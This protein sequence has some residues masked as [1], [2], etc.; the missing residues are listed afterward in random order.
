MPGTVQT[1][2]ITGDR[3]MKT[4]LLGRTLMAAAVAGLM[5]ASYLAGV[6]QGAGNEAV[7]KLDQ[8]NDLLVKGRA[9]LGSIVTRQGAGNIDKAKANID[10]ALSEMNKARTAN[11][12]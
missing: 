11:G 4:K 5:A 10:A 8:T 2:R 3:T 12:G 1:D 9:I 6:A 7:T